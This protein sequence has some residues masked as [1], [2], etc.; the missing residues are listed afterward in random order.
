MMIFEQ[1]IYSEDYADFKLKTILGLLALSPVIQEITQKNVEE[2]EFSNAIER[3]D[4]YGKA[5]SEL[6]EMEFGVYIRQAI[7]NNPNLLSL[8]TYYLISML[9]Y[10]HL[11]QMKEKNTSISGKYSNIFLNG[12]KNT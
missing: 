1:K 10:Q 12:G 4:F 2:V 3:L 6:S 5:A 9:T 8:R 11:A 7:E